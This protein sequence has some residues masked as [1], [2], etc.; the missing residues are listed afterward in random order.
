MEWNRPSMDAQGSP[1]CFGKELFFGI[2]ETIERSG[3][4]LVTQWLPGIF[5]LV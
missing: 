4:V 2:L 3:Q 1:E 5:C